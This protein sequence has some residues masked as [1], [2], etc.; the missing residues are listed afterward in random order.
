MSKKCLIIG[1][2]GASGS[3]KTLLA[4]KLAERV[5][6]ELG[7]AAATIVSEDCYYHDR[8]DLT[9]EE[10][11]R[12]NYDHPDSLETSL[13]KD[14]LTRLAAGET[15]QIPQYDF[16][17]HLRMEKSVTVVPNYVILLEGILILH[18]RQIRHLLDLKVY[19]DVDQEVCL[20]RRLKRDLQQRGRDLDSVLL[21]YE[22]HVRPMFLKYIRPSR[23][24]ADIV[25]PH[26]G[27]NDR[28]V[29]VL[30]QYIHNVVS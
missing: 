5:T 17:R 7:A 6:Q 28:A 15:V 22:Q 25:V 16:S 12:V 9:Y 11:C 14:H 20:T 27:E 18:Q 24:R 4:E 19:V 29:D 3:G 30:F 26:G 23:D 10:R 8:P 2:A 1:I 13:M 21:Q